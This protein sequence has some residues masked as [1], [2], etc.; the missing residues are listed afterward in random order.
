MLSYLKLAVRKIPGLERFARLF[1]DQRY[2]LARRHLRGVGLEIG[3]L[4]RPLTL[5]RNARA[6]YLDRMVPAQLRKHYPELGTRRLYVSLVANGE[7][8]GCIA[9]GSLRFLIANHVIEHLEDPMAAIELFLRKL[10]NG[11]ILFL[12]VP[13]MRRTFDHGRAE[14]TCEHLRE[15]HQS[16]S[17]HSRA[18]HFD[19]WAQHVEGL[20]GIAAKERAAALNA[21]GYSI[22]FHCWTLD[23]FRYFL[24]HLAETL[25][26]EI[27]DSLSWRNENIFIIRK[28]G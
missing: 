19:E 10:G 3:A 14:T 27:A 1:F 12:A 13:D 11:G 7:D 25:P 2:K 16:G 17:S 21:M 18:Q 23:G 28:T 6:H 20:S 9:D 4:D 15:D 5:P 22:H 26:L 8:L 24:D